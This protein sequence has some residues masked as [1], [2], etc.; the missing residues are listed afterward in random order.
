[1]KSPSESALEPLQHSASISGNTSKPRRPPTASDSP[2]APPATHQLRPATP[3]IP[4]PSGLPRQ[5]PLLCHHL[6]AQRPQPSERPRTPNERPRRDRSHYLPPG[7]AKDHFGT[8]R[9][10]Q[11][12]L[13][14]HCIATC[15]NMW[16]KG[17]TPISAKIWPRKRKTTS[18]HR[19]KREWENGA[20]PDGDRLPA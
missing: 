3:K 15:G 16:K 9:A 5:R 13:L 11:S 19:G 6:N 7:M 2:P 14:Q 10:P 8:Q 18:P 12:A 17:Q 1:M 20:D 4:E